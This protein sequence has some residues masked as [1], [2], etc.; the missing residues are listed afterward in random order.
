MK[1]EV[2]SLNRAQLEGIAKAAIKFHSSY[3]EDPGE[4]I[5]YGILTGALMASGLLDDG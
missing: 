3:E 1:K 4:S 5:A 2:G